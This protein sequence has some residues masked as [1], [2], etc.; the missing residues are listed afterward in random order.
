MVT[1]LTGGEN[2]T[3]II[4]KNIDRFEVGS[5][6]GQFHFDIELAKV[7]EPEEDDFQLLITVPDYETGTDDVGLRGV[8]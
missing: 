1:T 5:P 7:A 6:P 2:T 4:H 3:V 8:C